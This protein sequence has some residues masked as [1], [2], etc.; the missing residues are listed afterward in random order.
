MKK[1]LTLLTII[2]SLILN[3]QNN[4]LDKEKDTIINLDEVGFGYT[5]TKERLFDNILVL[6]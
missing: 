4:S 6:R 2:S 3:S 1:I 5:S